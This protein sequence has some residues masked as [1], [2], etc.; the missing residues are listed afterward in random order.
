MVLESQLLH[1]TGGGKL[2]SCAGARAT[3]KRH[4]VMVAEVNFPKEVASGLSLKVKQGSCRCLPGFIFSFSAT[5]AR[6]L[7]FMLPLVGT[8]TQVVLMT[9]ND[10]VIVHIQA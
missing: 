8:P 6:S 3:H 2:T 5:A 4:L 9:D 10:L 7:D 1:L